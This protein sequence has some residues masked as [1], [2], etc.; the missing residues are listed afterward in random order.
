MPLDSHQAFVVGCQ[1]YRHELLQKMQHCRPD[2]SLVLLRTVV[3][4]TNHNLQVEKTSISLN[5]GSNA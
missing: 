3:T 4:F 2:V 5:S 1:P